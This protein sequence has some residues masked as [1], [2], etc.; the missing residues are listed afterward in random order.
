MQSTYKLSWRQKVVG[1]FFAL[2]LMA[3]AFAALMPT[4]G[5]AGVDT[6]AQNTDEFGGG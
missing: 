2:M 1:S 6:I 5:D 4:A 3:S